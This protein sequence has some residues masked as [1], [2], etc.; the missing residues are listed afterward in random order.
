MAQ[1]HDEP[2]QVAAELGDVLVDGPGGVAVALTP[3]A[4][5]ETAHRLIEG[6]AHAQG[7]RLSG[8]TRPT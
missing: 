1:T 6:A 8:A 5:D 7:Q 2:S 3:D 4:A